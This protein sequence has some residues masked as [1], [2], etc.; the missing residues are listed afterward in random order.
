MA[1]NKYNANVIRL[2]IPDKVVEH[3][4]QMELYK[5]CGYSPDDIIETARGLMGKKK[6]TVN[7]I[8]ISL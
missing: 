7:Q 8:F 1:D 4:T 6:K 2:G 5:E 3:G